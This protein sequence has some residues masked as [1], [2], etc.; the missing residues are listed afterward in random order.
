MTWWE[1]AV[2][3]YIAELAV[4]HIRFRKDAYTFSLT[5]V[6]L[7]FGLFTAGRWELIR[8][9]AIGVL[10]ACPINRRQPP[11]KYALQTSK[12]T[13]AAG[14]APRRGVHR[15]PRLWRGAA[16][17]REPGPALPVHAQPRDVPRGGVRGRRAA[18]P[19]HGHL[20]RRTGRDRT[21]PDRGREHRAGRADPR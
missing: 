14:G 13:L 9:Q 11:I 21:V 5:E 17:A 3:S 18:A 16:P 1:L 7:V 15:L 20:P 10:A 19:G 12:L 4:V 6:V 8:G 2:A